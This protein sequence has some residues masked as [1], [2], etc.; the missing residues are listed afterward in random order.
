[1]KVLVLITWRRNDREK[2]L[3]I[4]FEISKQYAMSYGKEVKNFS[5]GYIVELYPLD[6]N[7]SFTPCRSWTMLPSENLWPKYLRIPMYIYS[8]IFLFIGVAI[9]SDKFMTSIEVRKKF[10]YS[11]STML[12]KKNQKTT[13]MQYCLASDLP[14]VYFNTT[15]IKNL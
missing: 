15:K 6:A 3:L 7:G 12:N 14:S 9:G 10:Y 5:H 13:V 11:L 2:F 4:F 8:L 1:M